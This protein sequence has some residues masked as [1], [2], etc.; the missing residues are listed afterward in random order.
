MTGEVTVAGET[1]AVK[2]LDGA[3]F[4]LEDSTYTVEGEA[5]TDGWHVADEEVT[6]DGTDEEVSLAGLPVWSLTVDAGEKDID[7]TIERD[8]DGDNPYQK[9]TR[10]TDEDGT[11]DFDVLPGTY[12]VTAE[13]YEPAEVQ[14]PGEKHPDDVE[15][16]PTDGDGDGDEYP[17]ATGIIRV[18]D[19]DGDPIEGET[20]ITF[21]EGAGETRYETDEN[22]EV[23]IE[24]AA[25]EP[26]DVVRYNVYVRDQVGSIVIMSDEYTGTQEEEF[27]VETGPHVHPATATIHITDR[28]GNPLEREFVTIWTEEAGEYTRITDENGELSIE[29]TVVGPDDSVEYRAYARD[30][31][32][33]E[34][35]IAVR[36]DEHH[37]VQTVDLTVDVGTN[38]GGDENE[39]TARNEPARM[40]HC[41]PRWPWLSDHGLG[42]LHC[43]EGIL[44]R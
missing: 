25:G 33:Q 36:S 29:T 20:V 8:L 26:T 12:S 37:G 1:K 28:D 39:A 11:A 40:E 10:T 31:E 32:E 2:G 19:Q 43:P 9:T 13:G 15:L 35:I 30:L 16:T 18:V 21:N 5:D 4:E 3:E 34:T 41:Q 6:I 38:E 7:V 17:T 22:G 23:V 27:V 42:A 44:R 14:V 24:L